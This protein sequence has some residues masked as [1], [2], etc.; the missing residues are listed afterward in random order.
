MVPRKMVIDNI[1]CL[2]NELDLVDVWRIKNPQSRSY[3]WSQKSPPIF[4]RLDYWL[5]SNNL[6]DFVNTTDIIPAIKT[7]H[8]AIELNLTDSNQNSKGPGFWKMNVSLLED[9]NYLE[10]LKQNIPLWKTTGSDN[11]SDKRCIWDWLKYNIRKHAI[12]FSKKKARERSAMEQKLKSIRGSNQ[13]IRTG[14]FRLLNLNTLN[15]AK[16]IL[17]SYYEEKTRGVTIRARARWH[18]HGERS[19]KYFLNLEKRNHVK[20][21]I[22]KTANKWFNYI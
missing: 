1:E 20:K 9:P 5:I 7:D 22:R 13:N 12:L 21:H 6:Q 15:E 3:T 16:N 14:P 11:L 10:E 4:C 8:A 17:E 19:T 18:E 2:Q